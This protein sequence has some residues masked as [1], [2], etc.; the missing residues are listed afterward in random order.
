MEA[1]FEEFTEMV[2]DLVEGGFEEN[3]SDALATVVARL[4]SRQQAYFDGIREEDREYRQRIREED[5]KDRERMREEDRKDRERIRE[6]DR[7]TRE[8]SERRIFAELDRIRRQDK[9]DRAQERR[10]IRED[11]VQMDARWVRSNRWVIT[12]LTT[13]VLSVLGSALLIGL[14]FL[15]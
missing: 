15:G 13:L 9:E 3:Q 8:E 11:L 14:R 6:E 2:S 12:T 5:R 7:K 4:F 1:K 10:E